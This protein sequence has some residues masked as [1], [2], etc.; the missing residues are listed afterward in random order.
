MSLTTGEET[1][2]ITHIN[3][4]ETANITHIN[5]EETANIT[6]INTEETANITQINTDELEKEDVRREEVQGH[7]CNKL[8]DNLTLFKFPL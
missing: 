8:S 4:E 2:N 5:T 7:R 6:Q 1:A 3:T